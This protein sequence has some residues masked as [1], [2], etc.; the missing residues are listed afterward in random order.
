MKCA[1]F[2]QLIDSHLEGGLSGS[3]RLEFDTHRLHCRHCELTVALMETVGHVIANDRPGTGLADD[4]TD[5]V[6]QTIERRRPLSVRLRST[7]VAVVIG[8]LLQAAAVIYLAIVLPS[9]PAPPPESGPAADLA[10]VYAGAD[11]QFDR[12]EALYEEILGRVEAARANFASE[13]TQLA[14]YPLALAVSDDFARESRAVTEKSPW[15]FLMEAAT[16]ER[17]DEPE[18]QPSTALDQHSL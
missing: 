11:D 16:P 14:R 17:P 15:S 13:W 7:R 6:M 1:A 3:L 2:E 8:G 12:G 4:F 10:R 18:P 5:R 9:T